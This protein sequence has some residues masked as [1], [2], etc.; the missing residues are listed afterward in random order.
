MIIL[1]D[2]TEVH[3]KEC[4]ELGPLYFSFLDATHECSSDNSCIGVTGYALYYT[5]FGGIETS[6]TTD[7]T[8]QLDTSKYITYR[9]SERFSKYSFSMNT[10]AHSS[11][12]FKHIQL[13]V[14]R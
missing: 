14:V 4:I 12:V 11:F 10:L 8:R 6:T 9:K 5:C 3:R 13:N 2:Y 1:D 7:K